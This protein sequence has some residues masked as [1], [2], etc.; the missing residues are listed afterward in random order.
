MNLDE[1]AWLETLIA[2]AQGHV[3]I[4]NLELLCKEAYQAITLLSQH[5]PGI[6]AGG[7]NTSTEVAPTQSCEHFRKA[8]Q[9]K[10][11]QRAR[12]ADAVFHKDIAAARL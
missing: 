1:P 6:P 4:Y 8:R 3:R 10:Q 5:H 12:L 9:S 7:A 2:V 11:Y